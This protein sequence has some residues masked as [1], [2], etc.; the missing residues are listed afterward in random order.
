MH[1]KRSM[2]SSVLGS[3]IVT[4][5][6]GDRDDN[7]NKQADGTQKNKIMKDFEYKIPSIIETSDQ[8]AFEPR[9]KG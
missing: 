7:Y 1:S 9:T 6:G 3:L 5:E 8:F 2:A 4:Y